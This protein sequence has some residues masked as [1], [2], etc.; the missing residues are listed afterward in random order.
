MRGR[1]CWAPSACLRCR[2]SRRSRRVSLLSC[3]CTRLVFACPC[4]RALVPCPRCRVVVL[5]CRR[6][7][8]FHVVVVVPGVSELGG[9]AWDG[10]VLTVVLYRRLGAT[11]QQRRGTW[12]PLAFH[13]G[14]SRFCACGRPFVFVVGRSSLFG[15]SSSLSGR[16]WIVVGDGRS[17]RCV[18]VVCGRGSVVSVVARRGRAVPWSVGRSGSERSPI[19]DDERRIRIRRSPFGCHVA[20]SDVAPEM[21]VCQ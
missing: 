10:G 1:E 21:D 11:S 12:F 8:F 20:V 14:G 6:A 19:D 3:P 13:G 2:S 4:C 15:G 9:R 7:F 5:Y 16:S 18:V 17:P